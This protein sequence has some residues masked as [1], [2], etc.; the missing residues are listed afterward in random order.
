MKMYENE[1]FFLNYFMVLPSA[2]PVRFPVRYRF[3]DK[4][5]FGCE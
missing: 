4:E 1:H 2:P 5:Q 3:E